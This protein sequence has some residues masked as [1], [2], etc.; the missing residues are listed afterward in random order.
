MAMEGEGGREKDGQWEG[1]GREIGYKWKGNRFA[2]LLK[3]NF[4]GLL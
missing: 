2:E 1:N 3:S 4:T